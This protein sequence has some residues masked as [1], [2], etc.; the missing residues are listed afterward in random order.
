MD[1]DYEYEYEYDLPT[2]R[3]GQTTPKQTE[4]RVYQPEQP[5]V[6]RTSASAFEPKN[7]QL[8]LTPQE[9][10]I[11][12][13]SFGGYLKHNR[14]EYYVDAYPRRVEY[15]LEMPGGETKAQVLRD[16]DELHTDGRL[17]NNNYLLGAFAGVVR[18]KPVKSDSKYVFKD[19]QAPALTRLTNHA[20]IIIPQPKQFLLAWYSGVKQT[21]YKLKRRRTL[22]TFVAK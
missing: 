6:G 12:H 15:K 3:T 11:G 4:E 19:A 1:S 9:N 22:L 7:F 16:L 2:Y 14:S 10:P 18:E 21:M 17:H 13:T 5:T 8:Y 20:F